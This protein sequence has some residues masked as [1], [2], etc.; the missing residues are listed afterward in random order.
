LAEVKIGVAHNVS[1]KLSFAGEFKHRVK[2]EEDQTEKKDDKKEA[3][4]P[5]APPSWTFGGVY[6]VD[7][8]STVSAKI[9]TTG[10]ANAAYKV[11]LNSSVT[12]TLAFETQVNNLALP[13]KV[14][15][16]F[17]IDA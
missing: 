3:P 16:S 11:R 5:L 2:P 6:V 4:K 10:V 14:G 9:S 7:S 1:P 13:S 17:D 12:T 15:V 8:D